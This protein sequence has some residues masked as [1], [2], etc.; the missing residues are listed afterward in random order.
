M[1]VTLFF[2]P[3]HLPPP[4]GSSE[5]GKPAQSWWDSVTMSL[6]DERALRDV[7]KYVERGE[8]FTV[9]NLTFAP[10][11]VVTLRVEE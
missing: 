5:R 4:P 9:G 1:R 10:G 7:Q 2:R 6:S 11:Q 8:G 3:P